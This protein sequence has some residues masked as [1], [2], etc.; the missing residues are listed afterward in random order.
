[1]VLDVVASWQRRY[2][3]RVPPMVTQWEAHNDEHSLRWLAMHE[4]AP[5]RYGLRPGEPVTIVTVARN[6]IAFADD[7]GVGEDE[8]CKQWA[9]DVAGCPFT[10]VP[11]IPLT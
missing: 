10:G 9:D 1:M 4:P 7:L 3:N 2:R 5:G 6:L 11:G 8:A